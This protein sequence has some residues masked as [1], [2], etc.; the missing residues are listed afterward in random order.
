MM[1]LSHVDGVVLNVYEMHNVVNTVRHAYVRSSG[2][3]TTR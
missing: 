2:P 1:K 3:N